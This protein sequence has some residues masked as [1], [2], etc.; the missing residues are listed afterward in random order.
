MQAVTRSTSGISELHNRIASPVQSCSCSGLW[1]YDA[2]VSMPNMNV[3]AMIVF[4][5]V[6]DVPMSARVARL[7]RRVVTCE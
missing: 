6:I 2:L 1:A 4:E 7:S 3:V 5:K